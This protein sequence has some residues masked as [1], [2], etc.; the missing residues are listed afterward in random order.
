MLPL[1]RKFPVLEALPNMLAELKVV[2][3]IPAFH[4]DAEAMYPSAIAVPC[5]VPADIVPN[6]V[7]AG[8]LVKFVALAY[9]E[10]PTFKFPLIT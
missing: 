1:A 7:V 2:V 10:P 5:Q 4:F 3:A 6:V 8:M 9:K